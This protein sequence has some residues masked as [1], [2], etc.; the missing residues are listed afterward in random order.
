MTA[1]LARWSLLILTVLLSAIWLPPAW[2]LLFGDRFGK[3]QLFY[4]PVIER[5]VY[6][7]LVG[8]GHQFIIATWMAG[9]TVARTSRRSSPSSTTR[10]WNSGG[11]C[12]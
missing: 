2:D 6:T 12:R 10:T 3:T 1:R 7:E 4:S 9:T 8:E 11:G 5:F